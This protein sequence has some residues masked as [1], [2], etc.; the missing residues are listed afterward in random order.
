MSLEP[1]NRYPQP[2]NT[3]TLAQTVLVSQISRYVLSSLAVEWMNNIR[4]E[5]IR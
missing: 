3:R 2:R 1:A 4:V 5:A